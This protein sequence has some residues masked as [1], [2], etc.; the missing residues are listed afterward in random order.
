MGIYSSKRKKK[1]FFLF[2][3]LF[4]YLFYCILSILLPETASAAQEACRF[5]MLSKMHEELLSVTVFWLIG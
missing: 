1:C 2:F 3:Y 5:D 4:I